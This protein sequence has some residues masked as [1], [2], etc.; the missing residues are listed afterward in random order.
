MPYGHVYVC[1]ACRP[2]A[3]VVAW[4]YL[5]KDQ[6]QYSFA[7]VAVGSTDTTIAADPSTLGNLSN[8]LIQIDDEL[9]LISNINRSTAQLTV[10]A[11]TNGRGVEG[12]VAA[13]HAQNAL[14]VNDPTFPRAAIKQAINDTILGMFPDVFVVKSTTVTKSAPQYEY[15]LPVDVVDIIQ[16]HSDT[17]GPSQ[18]NFANY[19]YR[20]NPMANTT[21][22]PTG[23]SIQVLDP[24]TPGR[25]IW[26]TYQAEPSPLVNDT[27]DV[28]TV[29]GWNSDA[30]RYSDIIVFG[31]CARLISSYET[32]RL[33]QGAIEQS[34]RASLVPVQSAS[35]ASQYFWQ[36]Y[37]QRLSEERQR[38]MERFQTTAH[39]NR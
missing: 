33:Q 24:V 2:S 14:I 4:L 30:N 23:K 28:G 36:Q 35:K 6:E 22:F 16:V 25:S 38:L 15:G 19:H 1:S 7:T 13:S 29:T 27:D 10:L 12:T 21:R 37:Q 34:E 20:F 5:T 31:A 26:V 11:G 3:T 18:I 9:I 17:V 39:Y 8:G 32:A